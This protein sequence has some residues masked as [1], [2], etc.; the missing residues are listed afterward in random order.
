MPLAGP[1][2]AVIALYN[3]VGRWNSYFDALIYLSTPEKYPLQLVIRN[4]LTQNQMTNLDPG[5]GVIEIE[6]IMKVEGMKYGTI[7][8]STLPMLIIYPF[9]Q[10]Y[11][12]KGIF[13]GSLKG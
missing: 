6:N 9:V 8:V 7:I 4:L 10:K 13:V 12:V 11:F 1:I 3:I 5:A 2:I